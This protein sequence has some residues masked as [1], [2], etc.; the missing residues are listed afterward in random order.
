MAREEVHSPLP[1]D[2]VL[3]MKRFVT[4]ALGAGAIAA[5]SGIAFYVGMSRSIEWLFALAYALMA[6]GLFLAFFLGL[7]SGAHGAVIHT[8]VAHYV[9]T[10]LVWW[11]FLFALASLPSRQDGTGGRQ[12][13]PDSSGDPAGARDPALIR[14][15][16]TG[17][18]PADE[19]DTKSSTKAAN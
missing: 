2:Q 8:D 13:T 6:P 11:G 14:D 12:P 19:N 15:F 1:F 9:L 18:D 5:V 10:F 16:L 17:A 3:F 4:S 7:G